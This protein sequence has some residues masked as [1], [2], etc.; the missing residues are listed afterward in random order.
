MQRVFNRGFW[1]GGYYLGLPSNGASSGENQATEQK[2]FVGPVTNWFLK[3]NAAQCK[4][5]AEPLCNGDTVIVTGATT[6]AERFT[7]QGLRAN[8]IPAEKAE[9]GTNAT[10]A[11][12][13]R[14][15]ENDKVYLVRKNKLS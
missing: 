15:R 7:I 8:G 14:L 5:Q 4:V 13:V 2:I 1:D 12:P 10:F 9:K 3:H 6:G 11:A